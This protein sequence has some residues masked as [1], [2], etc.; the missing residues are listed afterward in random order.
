MIRYETFVTSE[1][2]MSIVE[3]KLIKKFKKIKNTTEGFANEK[4]M[5][6]HIKNYRHCNLVNVSTVMSS[7]SA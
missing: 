5:Q 7:V 1:Y 3:F 4:K 2:Y 6:S